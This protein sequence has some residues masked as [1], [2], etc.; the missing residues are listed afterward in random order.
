MK[1]ANSL[2][3]SPSHSDAVRRG[4]YRRG[5]Y[6]DTFVWKLVGSLISELFA[7]NKF[8]MMAIVT[9][10]AANQINTAVTEAAQEAVNSVSSV[11]YKFLLK[12]K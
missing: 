3:S 4:Q 2:H 9:E 5:I 7:T 8:E 1:C 10:A 6:L 11:F 12:K